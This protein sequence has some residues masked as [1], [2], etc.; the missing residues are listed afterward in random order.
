MEEGPLHTALVFR[1]IA[2]CIEDKLNMI[3]QMWSLMPILL[4]QLLDSFYLL[5][6]I[7]LSCS[8][9]LCILFIALPSL[10]IAGLQQ[11]NITLQVNAI[12]GHHTWFS[13][14]G[15]FKFCMINTLFSSTHQL[16]FCIWW[17]CMLCNHPSRTVAAIPSWMFRVMPCAELLEIAS[18]SEFSLTGKPEWSISFLYSNNFLCG[19][20]Y[21]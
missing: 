3:K 20:Y 4:T 21:W 11:S 12:T 6:T 17:P 15:S 8:S 18:L 7:C 13:F 16:I 10:F 1:M 19:R 9:I 5:Q 14:F 2:F